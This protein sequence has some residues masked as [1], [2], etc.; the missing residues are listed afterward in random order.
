MAHI[1]ELDR[2]ISTR[3]SGQTAG[4][5]YGTL[6]ACGVPCG[7]VNNIADAFAMAE[8]L[9]LNPLVNVGGGNNAVSLPANPISMSETP[10]S[11]VRRPPRLGQDSDDV[12]AWLHGPVNAKLPQQPNHFSNSKQQ[13]MGAHS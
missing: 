1:D 4:Y 8:E 3:T 13:P 11:Y 6:S 9:G 2:L 10:V 5:W 12:S 7:P